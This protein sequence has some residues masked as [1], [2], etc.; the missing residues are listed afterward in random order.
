MNMGFNIII[1]QRQNIMQKEKEGESE[2]GKET[3][4]KGD[5]QE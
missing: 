5:R 1:L 2:R 3:Q 4:S